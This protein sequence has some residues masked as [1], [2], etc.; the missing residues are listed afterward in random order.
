MTVVTVSA[1]GQV[2]IPAVWRRDVGLLPG[3]LAQIVKTGVG[4]L[5]KPV[6]KNPIDACFGKYVGVDL[7]GAI[8]KGRKL[9]RKREK[10]LES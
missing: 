3:K 5:V 9:D 8:K 1:K 6:A 2:V 10:R 4:V 7:Y